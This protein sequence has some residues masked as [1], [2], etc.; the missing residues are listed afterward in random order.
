MPSGGI[1]VLIVGVPG[2]IQRWFVSELV[3]LSSSS[4]VGLIALLWSLGDGFVRLGQ[5]ALSR[6]VVL[7]LP[8]LRVL[9]RFARSIRSVWLATALFAIVVSTPMMVGS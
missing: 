2:S 6:N 3:P 9:C 5:R 4:A 1:R 7:I 8:A